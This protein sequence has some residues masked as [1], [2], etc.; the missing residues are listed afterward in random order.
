MDSPPAREPG[1]PAPA[2]HWHACDPDVR[3]WVESVADIL[4]SGLGDSLI[5]LYLHGSLATGSFRR[6]KSDVDLFTVVSTRPDSEILDKLA[7]SLAAACASC[8]TLG[9][10]ELRIV[11][12][13]DLRPFPPL[14]PAFLSFSHG[15]WIERGPEIELPGFPHLEFATVSGAARRHGIALHG[16]PAATGIAPVP[17]LSYVA[18]VMDDLRWI[19]EAEHVLLTPIYAILN[20]CRTLAV[21]A[22]GESSGLP[23]KDAGA[24]WALA[25]LPCEHHPLI[26]RAHAAYASADPIPYDARRTGGLEWDQAPLLAFRDFAIAEAERR[27]HPVPRAAEDG[28][29]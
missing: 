10:L 5:G 6:P 27:G 1:P 9:G 24:R 15:A 21:L 14:G 29:R 8:P 23:D 26:R 3:A 17:W 16:P 28:L 20:L 22:E 12:D 13:G 25:H 18:S 7:A 19:V 4:Q 11:R 2:Q